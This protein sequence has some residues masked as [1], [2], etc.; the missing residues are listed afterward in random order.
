M[1]VKHS[2][3]LL[4]TAVAAITLAAMVSSASAVMLNFSEN[5]IR[6]TWAEVR[7][8]SLMLPTCPLTVE[9]SFHSQNI[10]KRVESLIG[11]ITRAIFGPA[12][13]CVEPATA[14]V[15]NTTLP[16][17]IRYVNFTGAL[18]AI[19]SMGTA[20]VGAGFRI[21]NSFGEVCLFTT[22]TERPIRATFNRAAGGELTS[23]DLG[24]TISAGIECPGVTTT[25]G[26]RSTTLTVLG[27]N[28]AI[29]LRLI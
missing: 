1:V 21:R 3:A 28:T 4:A 24:G 13:T 6:A 16:W 22:T 29:R 26:G 15:L 18:P 17:H 14:I 25:I 20:I 7:F 23:I 12:E 5:N 2:R 19:T 9:G 10:I 11:Y 8:G 27:T